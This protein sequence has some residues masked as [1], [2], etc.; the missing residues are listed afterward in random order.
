VTTTLLLDIKETSVCTLIKSRDS[1]NAMR[2]RTQR[3]SGNLRLDQ[4]AMN[5][6]LAL[7]M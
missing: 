7:L 5:Q 1:R 6:P 3:L 2:F 4:P